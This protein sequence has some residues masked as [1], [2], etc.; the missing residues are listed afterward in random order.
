VAFVAPAAEYR[1][2]HFYQRELPALLAVLEQVSEPLELVL[3]DGYVWLGRE[4]PG[5]GFHLWQH[6]GGRH[7]VV[8]VAKNAFA[9]NDL[10]LAVKRGESA[11]PL[12]VTSE[13]LNVDEAAEQVR[14]MHG[15]YRVPTLLKQVDTL[16]RMARPAQHKA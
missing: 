5:L 14:T 1:P 16:C 10:A 2:G 9:G 4:R 7:A 3:V 6:R 11:K 15:A 8:G 12:Y 13:G